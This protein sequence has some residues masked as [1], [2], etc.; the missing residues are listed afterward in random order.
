MSAGTPSVNDIKEFID[1]YGP[2]RLLYGSD[3][4]FATPLA[5]KKK[6]L[7]LNLP[8]AEKELI[9]SGNIMR[10]LKNTEKKTAIA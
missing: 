1:K 9:F 7:E 3:Y 4:P 8:P 2:H 5:C 6:I 10:L